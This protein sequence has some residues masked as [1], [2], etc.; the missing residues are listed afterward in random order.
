MPLTCNRKGCNNKAIQPDFRPSYI[1]EDG[2]SDCIGR[3]VTCT[4]CRNV[5]DYDWIKGIRRTR[6]SQAKRK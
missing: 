5:N 4:R 3:V 1:D 2:D 6:K